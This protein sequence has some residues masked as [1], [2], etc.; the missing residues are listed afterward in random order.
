MLDRFFCGWESLRGTSYYAVDIPPEIDYRNIKGYLESMC[1]KKILDY[2][3][4]CLSKNHK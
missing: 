1:E 3:E 2:K 4:A